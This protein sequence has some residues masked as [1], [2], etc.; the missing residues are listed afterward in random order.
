MINKLLSLI[1]LILLLLSFNFILAYQRSPLFGG[2]FLVLDNFG[3][4]LQWLALILQIVG[5]FIL[6]KGG[7]PKRIISTKIFIVFLASLILYFRVKFDYDRYFYLSSN[8]IFSHLIYYLALSFLLSLFFFL[9]FEERG[10][11]ISDF[12]NSF[13]GTSLLIL[14]LSLI[15]TL[16]SKNQVYWDPPFTL[17]LLFFGNFLG[18]IF[19]FEVLRRLSKKGYI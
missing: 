8:P 16:I 12:L 9:N 19:I 13:K 5:V 11:K 7:K 6:F 18:L 17:L 10:P 2:T 14:L 15:G 4:I 1:A 3:V